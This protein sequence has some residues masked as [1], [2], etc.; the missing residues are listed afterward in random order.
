M[1]CCLI[2]QIGLMS[3]QRPGQ[4]NSYFNTLSH[5]DKVLQPSGVQILVPTAQAHRVRICSVTRRQNHILDT[6]SFLFLFKTVSHQFFY[7]WFIIF[8]KFYADIFVGSWVFICMNLICKYL[9]ISQIS[10]FC[11]PFTLLQI[12]PE[13]NFNPQVYWKSFC[14]L[15]CGLF[16]WLL[17][18][19]VF[20]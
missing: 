18:V 12:W 3:T 13:N 10:R 1:F 4:H 14:D 11:F 19:Y 17:H 20:W 8:A 7:V 2:A 6:G 9:G 5:T 15:K 16:W